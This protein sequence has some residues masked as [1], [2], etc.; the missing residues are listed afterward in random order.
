MSERRKIA[1][2]SVISSGRSQ[3]DIAKAI[4]VKAGNFSSWLN[5]KIP[6]SKENME[7]LAKELRLASSIVDKP[8]ILNLELDMDEL[9]KKYLVMALGYSE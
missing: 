3:A 8:E 9:E 5:C 6:M 7:A 1:W 2:L 4:N